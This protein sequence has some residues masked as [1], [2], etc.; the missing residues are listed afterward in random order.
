MFYSLETFNVTNGI[1]FQHPAET[2]EINEYF[3]FT[4]LRNQGLPLSVTEKLKQMPAE[5]FE[6]AVVYLYSA[7]ERRLE[8]AESD[9]EAYF[10]DQLGNYD[11]VM[12]ILPGEWGSE[13]LR[14][15]QSAMRSFISNSL[16]TKMLFT[17][18]HNIWYKPF[19][20]D[21][22][23]MQR[24]H[25][26]ENRDIYTLPEI[27]AETHFLIE[28]IGE[29]GETDLWLS[30][31]TGSVSLEGILDRNAIV[32]SY[33]LS[34]EGAKIASGEYAGPAGT[35]MGNVYAHSGARTSSYQTKR[36]LGEYG[37]T[38]VINK[39]RQL[40]WLG[41]NPDKWAY[42]D[43]PIY[44]LGSN[45]DRSEG[46]EVGEVVPLENIDYI[47]SDSRNIQTIRSKLLIRGLNIPVISCEAIDI[48]N[49]PEVREAV[50][51]LR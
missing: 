13:T 29:L 2:N 47:L 38:F 30:H 43:N 51:R 20:I 3:G 16:P 24:L 46:V 4:E 11:S 35:A 36:W 50:L 49:S 14:K 1:E 22:K 17:M 10:L 42:P 40:D 19:F 33:Q 6:D 15:F 9:E 28:N 23:D 7:H 5:N 12:A 8:L 25:V 31:N 48:M 45:G 18:Y 32:N 21:T 26:E 34:T 27:I 44:G 41:R 39:Q 37:L